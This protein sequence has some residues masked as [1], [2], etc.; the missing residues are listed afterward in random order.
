MC[1]RKSVS[2]S[3][4]TSQSGR[5]VCV[6]GLTEEEVVVEEGAAAAGNGQSCRVRFVLL[7]VG[8]VVVVMAMVT[9]I[10]I[11]AQPLILSGRV[12]G[13]DIVVREFRC[14]PVN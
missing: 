9:P 12:V 3:Q 2:Q 14:E 4:E 5:S 8:R 13:V 11:T 7:A 10:G 1:R 6:P